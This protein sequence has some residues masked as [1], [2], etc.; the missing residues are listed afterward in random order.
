MSRICILLIV[1]LACCLPVG[2]MERARNHH[3]SLNF[4]GRDRDYIVHVPSACVGKKV[5]LVVLLHG[6]LTNAW[7]VA[8]ESKMSEKADTDGFIVAYPQGSGGIGNLLLTW[9]AGGCCGPAKMK[10]RDDIGFVRELILQVQ[11][12]FEID[13]DRIYVAGSSNGGM[14]AYQV[15]AELSDIVAGIGCV[16]GCLV[17]DELNP[18]GPLSV[19][20]FNGTKDKVIRLKGG[21]GSMLGYKIKCQAAHETIEQLAKKIGC[22]PESKKESVGAG[23]KE[24]FSGGPGG[25]EVCLYS[26]PIAHFWPGGRRP[27]PNLNTHNEEINATD[28]MCEFFW[29]HPK[30]RI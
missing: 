12:D 8:F 29:A 30:H 21:V 26:V 7:F 28:L 15:G 1:L 6:G 14:L 11:K 16:N 4:A 5:P 2:A 25:T 18:K 20:A 19:V 23:T 10:H 13:P 17:A 24:T 9:N 3:S 22:N 27:Y